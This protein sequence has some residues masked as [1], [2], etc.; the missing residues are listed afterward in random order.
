MIKLL[1][2]WQDLAAGI[3]AFLAGILGFFAA[4][5]AV[6][7]TL[8]SERRRDERELFAIKRALTAEIFQFATL[9]TGTAWG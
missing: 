1:R 9:M 7:A 3:L 2:E 5:W 8:R 6:S 4:I